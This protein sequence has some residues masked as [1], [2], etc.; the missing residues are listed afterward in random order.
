LLHGGRGILSGSGGGCHI[1]SHDEHEEGDAERIHRSYMLAEFPEK[2]TLQVGV[3]DRVEKK[4]AVP[5][6]AL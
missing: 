6:L 3:G 5:F 2:S 4:T 1:S